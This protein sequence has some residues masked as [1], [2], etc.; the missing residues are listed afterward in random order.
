MTKELEEIFWKEDKWVDSKGKKVKPEPI[1]ASFNI[2]IGEPLLGFHDKTQIKI[3]Q[4]IE[5]RINKYEIFSTANAYYTCEP[6][7]NSVN[8]DIKRVYTKYLPIQICKI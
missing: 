6:S 4:S 5:E 8:T 3:K 2:E 1:R 7:L